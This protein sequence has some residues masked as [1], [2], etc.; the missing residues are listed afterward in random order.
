MPTFSVL[1][2][3]A[4]PSGQAAEAGGAFVKI[5]GREALLRS[6]ELFLN[7]DAVKQ[8]QLV[9]QPDN[10]EESKRK[11]GAHLSFSGV[12]L[13]SGG[14]RWG[15]QLKAAVTTISDE[16]THVVIHDAAR[17]VV[18]FSDI[19]ALFAAAEEHEAVGLMSPV[20]S[21][22]IQIDDS[23]N[24]LHHWP[25]DEFVQ[26]QTPQVLSKHQF[27]ATAGR[28]EPLPLSIAKLIKGSP[29]NERIRGAGDA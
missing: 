8:I 10:L 27:L 21:P 1:I 3:T 6:M 26:L 18:P 5:D 4:A 11:Y 25:A 16:A 7:R 2:L 24:A 22:L 15:D 20:R 13:L 23:G 29:L 28:G 9:I 12:K 14:P 19:D 17:P